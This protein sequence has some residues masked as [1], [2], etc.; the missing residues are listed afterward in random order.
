MAA[1]ARLVGAQVIRA[2][3]ALCRLCHEDLVWRREPITK[4]LLPAEIAWQ[5]VG[6][7]RPDH[8]FQDSPD[9]VAIAR[10]R[11]TNYGDGFQRQLSH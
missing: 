4:R 1:T 5:R 3:N 7:P 9:A 6:L 2:E 10:F 11:Q 8:R